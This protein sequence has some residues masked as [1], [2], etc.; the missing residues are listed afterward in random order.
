MGRINNIYHAH[1]F[2]LQALSSQKRKIFMGCGIGS[3]K[4]ET[5]SLWVLQKIKNQL[6]DQI[7]VITANSYPQL[8]DSTLRRL[9]INWRKWGISFYPKEVPRQHSPFSI[10]VW[11]GNNWV[12]ILCRSLDSYRMLSGQELAW[13]WCDEVWQTKKEAVELVISRLRDERNGMNRQVLFTTTL[14]DPDTWMYEFCEEPDD[15]N[16]IKVIYVSTY[17]N[18]ENLPKG[19][20]E[21]LRNTY[22]PQM[23]DRMVMAKWVI[24]GT[25]IIYTGWN[26]SR[27]IDGNITFDPNLPLIWTWDFNIGEGKPMSSAIG[28]MKKG[29]YEKKTAAGYTEV[30]HRNE[31]HWLDEI[32]IESTDTNQAIDEFESRDWLRRLSG[33]KE[34]VRIFGDRCGKSRDTRSKTTDYGIIRDRGYR[35]QLVPTV[36]PPIRER[37]NVVNALLLNAA[38]DVKMKVHPRCK[39][40]I[41]GIETARLKKG[42]EYLEEET[43]EQHITTAVGYYCCWDFPLRPKGFKMAKIGGF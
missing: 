8:I 43:R 9:F 16:S 42:A 10:W 36:N 12:E 19:Y 17:E 5:G 4:T 30:I 34:Q 15:P 7:S 32:V 27:N 20:I 11:N 14:D 33:G 24:L 2:Q 37:H 40:L 31:I 38:G 18:E 41:K 1:D 39:T 21:D 13:A 22:S 26:R 28:Q 25:S 6:S 35:T 29:T 23:F 3:G